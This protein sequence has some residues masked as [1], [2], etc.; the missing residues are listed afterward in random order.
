MP[1]SLTPPP[2]DDEIEC[3]NCGAYVYVELT[4]CPNCGIN[5]YEPEDS[6]A[7]RPKFRPKSKLFLAIESL[8]RKLRRKPHPAEELFDNALREASV[9]NDLLL[10]VGGDRSVVERL[11]AYEHQLKPGATRLTCLQHAILRW[12]QENQR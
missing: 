3:A 10:K 9:F 12:E 1:T 5:L 6:P 11:I 2:A 7:G 4:R 8:L